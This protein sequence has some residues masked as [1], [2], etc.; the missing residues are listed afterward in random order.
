MHFSLWMI[1]TRLL[2]IAVNVILAFISVA[3]H[4]VGQTRAISLQINGHYYCKTKQTPG[5][6]GV[7]DARSARSPTVQPIDI[8]GERVEVVDCFTYLGSRVT[9]DGYSADDIRRRTGLTYSNMDKSDRVWN[10]GR[11]SLN[12]KLRIYSCCMLA[13]WFG[14]L[15]TTKERQPDFQACHAL[16]TSHVGHILDWPLHE[17]CSISQNW[18]CWHPDR[19]SLHN[20]MIYPV[21]SAGRILKPRCSRGTSS[22]PAATWELTQ[23]QRGDDPW[24]DHVTPRLPTLSKTPASLQIK[25]GP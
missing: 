18:S 2:I 12:V 9:S 1:A 17:C 20:V 5:S 11:L 24:L 21:V 15:D 4:I 25:C 19:A 6:G 13:V 23:N 3:S 10:S 7:F 16:S 14:D 22:R 8:H